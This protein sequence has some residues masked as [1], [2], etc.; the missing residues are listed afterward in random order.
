MQNLIIPCCGKSSRFPGLRPKFLLTAPSG[1]SM[2]IESLLGI[3]QFTFDNVYFVVLKEHVEKYNFLHGIE[4]QYFPNCCSTDYNQWIIL[5]EPTKNQP[6]T[7]YRAIKQADIQGQI[8]IK[9]VDN[10]FEIDSFPQENFVAVDNLHNHTNINAANKSYAMISDKG[11][12]ENIV[13]KKIVSEWFCT[14]LYSFQTSASFCAYYEDVIE[15][16]YFGISEAA[17]LYI[18]HIIYRML[19]DNI[20]FCI[21]EVQNFIDWGELKEWNKYCRSFMNIEIDLDGC[22]VEASCPYMN[23][24][25]GTTASLRRN[26]EFINEKYNEGRAHIIVKTARP[27]S[28]RDLTKN[29][30]FEIGLKYHHLIMGAFHAPRYIVNDFA[31]TNM[32]PAASAVNLPRNSDNL[33]EYFE[34]HH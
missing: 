3:P 2:L 9:D 4:N 1:N 17:N 33:E 34:N 15:N 29:Q 10:Y 24:L 25:C 20:T 7:V 14:G 16:N 30:L 6:E 21:K 12:I 11:L 26:V 22:L 5:D 28:I 27:E 18:S 23:P 13:E 8:L 19:L 31:N 32:Y